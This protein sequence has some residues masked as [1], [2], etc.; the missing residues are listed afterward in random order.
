MAQLKDTLISGDLKVTGNYNGAFYYVAGTAGTNAGDW[1][2]YLSEVSTPYTGLKLA[3][4]IPI[5]GNN[6][7]TARTLTNDDGTTVSATYT[8]LKFNGKWY[9]CYYAATDALTTHYNTVNSVVELIFD[10][11]LN[12]NAG[13]FRAFADYNSNTTNAYGYLDFYFRP[14]VGTTLYRYK[15]CALD[16]DNRLQPIVTTNQENATIVTKTPNTVALRPYKIWWYNTTTTISAGTVIGA[17][18]LNAAMYTTTCPYNFNASIPAYRLVY[19]V[20]S[21]NKDTD[22][23]TLE[24]GSNSYYCSVPTNTASITLSSYFTSGKYYWLLGGTYSSADYIS[25]FAYNP[26]YYFD[27]TN[28]VPAHRNT[29]YRLG[30]MQAATPSSLTS[31][32]PIISTG[33]VGIENASMQSI[34]NAFKYNL[35]SGSGS[36]N[37]TATLVLGDNETSALGLTGQIKIFGTGAYGTTIKGGALTADREITLPNTGGTLALTSNIPTTASSHTTGITVSTNG[38][39]SVTGV[40]STTTTASHVKSGGNGSAPTLGTAFTIPNVTAAGSGSFSATVT[41]HVLS[42]SHGHTP[43][44]L[45]TAFTVPNVTSAGSASNWVFE[46]ITVPIKNTSATSVPT[47]YTVTDNGHTHTL[48]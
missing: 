39:T 11:T 5:A 2:A 27:G 38:T 33:S 29:D 41:N 34:H 45:G 42:F 23:F 48:S 13:G 9:K 46:D 8:W 32:S 26:L 12:S 7:S 31:Y 14:Y 10:S 17:N 40:Q 47:S 16:K 19:L 30:L 25:L 35:V 6:S 15:F 1:I 44:T 3:Y 22:L 18:V 4:K 20:G 37:G 36:T 28:L 24:S 43:P 21:Y